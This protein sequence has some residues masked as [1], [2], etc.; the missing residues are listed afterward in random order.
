M[1]FTEALQDNNSMTEDVLREE[2][3]Q[4]NDRTSDQYYIGDKNHDLSGMLNFS[5]TNPFHVK[6]LELWYYK[7][8]G[9]STFALNLTLTL[10]SP[11]VIYLV[12]MAQALPKIHCKHFVVLLFF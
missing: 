10:K 5:T 6:H 11:K 3:R 4:K 9:Y 7:E 1:K 2:L 12:F 8:L